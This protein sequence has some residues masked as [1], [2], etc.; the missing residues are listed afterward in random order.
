MNNDDYRGIAQGKAT[1]SKYTYCSDMKI[2]HAY[3]FD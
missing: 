1:V 2:N 3:L